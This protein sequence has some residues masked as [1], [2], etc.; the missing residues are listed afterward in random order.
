MTPEQKLVID[1]KEFF[2]KLTALME[3]YHVKSFSA[4]EEHTGGD[5]GYNVCG[6]EFHFDW[7]YNSEKGLYRHGDYMLLR[8]NNY[9][10]DLQSVVKELQTAIDKFKP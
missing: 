1:K 8:V 10:H 5:G 2:E 9:V 7:L 3:E 4:E 6:V